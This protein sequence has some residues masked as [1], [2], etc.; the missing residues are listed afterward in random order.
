MQHPSLTLNMI[1]LDSGRPEPMQFQLYASMREAIVTKQL[2]AGGRLPSTRELAQ[3]WRVSRNTVMGAFDQLTAEGYLEGKQGAGTFVSS[4]IPDSYS[5][6]S[7][8]GRAS[9]ATVLASRER[10]LRGRRAKYQG[11]ACE[12]LPMMPLRPTVPSLEDFPFTIWEQCRKA[13]VRQGEAS[14]LTYGDPLGYWPLRRALATYLRDTRGVRCEPEQVIISCGSQQGIYLAAS[15]LLEQGETVWMEDPG[16]HGARMVY[17]G[18]GTKVRPVP[19]DRQGMNIGR[20]PVH[21]GAARLIHI[22][23][24]HQFPL[25]YTMSLERRLELLDYAEQSGAYIVED[26]YDSEFRY[27]GR[28]ISSL[29]G[30]DQC[31]S[32]I[33]VGT[34]SKILFPSLRLG[35]IVVPPGLV[36]LFEQ[37]RAKIDGN[38]TSIDPATIAL[39]MEEG[40]FARHVRRM[41][42]LYHARLGMLRYAVG[43]HLPGALEL[44]EQQCG[45]HAVG[46]LKSEMAD[47]EVSAHARKNGV[48]APALSEYSCSGDQPPGLVLGFAGFREEEIEKAVVR[49]AESIAGRVGRGFEAAL[50]TR[51][52]RAAAGP[53]KTHVG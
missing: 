15:T 11:V 40:H 38:P 12:R 19:V 50:S 21:E 8:E 18:F 28:A 53:L 29:Q 30:L 41:R 49:L 6:V 3:R 43:R 14:L 33:Y 22:S 26:D 10:E 7:S 47:W 35:Y 42:S 13:V 20:A 25:G 5:R 51:A 45:M 27:E 52:G 17:E 36:D 39:F 32:V 46:W 34:F 24:S 31:G 4:R 9:C 1:Q 44:E 23:P 2:V 16:Y 37:T 48:V